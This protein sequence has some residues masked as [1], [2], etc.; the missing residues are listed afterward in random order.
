MVFA[1]IEAKIFEKDEIVKK[2]L[3]KLNVDFSL[4]LLQ[5]D[6]LVSNV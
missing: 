2:T 3:A 6:K 1:I 5:E 4:S